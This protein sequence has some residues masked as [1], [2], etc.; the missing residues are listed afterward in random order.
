MAEVNSA[1]PKDADGGGQA[2]APTNEVKIAEVTASGAGSTTVSSPHIVQYPRPPK[3]DDG[4]WIA[5]ASVI[6]NII[7]KLSNQKVIKEAK[8]AEGKWRDVMAKMKDIA[9]R[10]DG[11]VTPKRD[12]ADIV[13]GDLDDRTRL[14]FQRADSE[15][16]YSKRLENCIDG[17]QDD[18]CNIASCGYQ[19]DYDGIRIRVQADAAKSYAKEHE[20]ICRMTNRYN[21]GWACETRN[22]LAIATTNSVIAATNQARETERLNK[23]KYDFETRKTMLEQLERIRESRNQSSRAYENAALTVRGNQYQWH[24]SE[25]DKSLKYA[26]DL[27]SAHGQNAAWLADSLRKTAKDSMSDWGTLATMIAGLVLSWNSGSA[28]AVSNDCGKK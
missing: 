7:G 11:R 21:T 25:A 22:R 5:L 23:W 10:E 2:P 9:D 4:R 27:L 28:A 1:N 13:M 16:N 15:Y 8:N 3:R 20:K 26:A 17:L 6:G 19:P 12:Q 24:I 18:L 14:G